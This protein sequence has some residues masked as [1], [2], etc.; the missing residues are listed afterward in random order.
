MGGGAGVTAASMAL[1]RAWKLIVG[2]FGDI[3]GA[4]SRILVSLP[5]SRSS[6][7]LLAILSTLN[8]LCVVATHIAKSQSWDNCSGLR[9]LYR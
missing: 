2:M 9:G 7:K 5:I 8:V 6:A 3:L 1:A 4:G